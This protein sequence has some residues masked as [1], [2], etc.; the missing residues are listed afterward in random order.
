MRWLLFFIGTVQE[1]S[2]VEVWY[3][4]FFTVTFK[5]STSNTLS[6]F[7]PTGMKVRACM[8]QMSG[9]LGEDTLSVD[10]GS[11]A[12]IMMLVVDA[13]RTAFL[14]AMSK[15]CTLFNRHMSFPWL[16]HACLFAFSVPCLRLALAFWMDI[17]IV[18]I[19][20]L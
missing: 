18:P 5:F 14:I 13:Q 2:L 16:S 15:R 3:V 19:T 11:S 8:S 6:L 12:V 10:L 9:K 17:L 20:D 1:G 7:S 4:K